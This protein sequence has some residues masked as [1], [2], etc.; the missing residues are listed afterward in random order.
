ML[1]G[2]VAESLYAH[3]CRAPV[4]TFLEDSATRRLLISLEGKELVAVRSLLHPAVSLAVMLGLC[5]LHCSP[6][7]LTV[8]PLA[9][10]G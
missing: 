5:G 8:E 10:V 3:V 7:L 1:H 2:A 6:F 4:S 9:C